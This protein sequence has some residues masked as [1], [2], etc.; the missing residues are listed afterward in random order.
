[1]AIPVSLFRP[2]GPTRLDSPAPPAEQQNSQAP[3]ALTVT[4]IHAP[5]SMPT[6]GGA[7][8]L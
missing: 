2:N 1:M 4:L 8:E 7:V 5:P 6:D 3:P